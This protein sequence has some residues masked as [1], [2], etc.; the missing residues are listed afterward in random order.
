MWNK[1]R[2]LKRLYKRHTG[3]AS[4]T[5]GVSFLAGLFTLALPVAIGQYYSFLFGYQSFKAKLLVFVP[6]DLT[7]INKFLAFFATLVILRV[8]FSFGEKY[9]TGV[10]GQLFVFDVRNLLFEHQLKIPVRDYEDKG[11]GRYLLRF[12]GDLNSIRRYVTHGIIRFI[13]DTILILLSIGL[14]FRLDWRLG[15]FMILGLVIPLVV[16]LR[17]QNTLSTVTRRQRN[18]KSKLLAFA[19]TRLQ[20]VHTIQLFNKEI[21]EQAKFTRIAKSTLKAGIEY[22]KIVSLI[23]ALIPGLLYFLLAGLFAFVYYVFPDKTGSSG[24]DVLIFI[25]ILL[26]IMPV[27]RRMLR[28]NIIWELGNISFEK[29]LNVFNRVNP[30]DSQMP[31]LV[32]K[33]GEIMI[34][35]LSYRFSS[36]NKEL[37]RSLSMHIPRNQLTVIEGKSG[38]GKTTLIKL[39]SGLYQAQKGTIIIDDCDISK[40][41]GK[42][43][44]RK[45]A[46]I[47][48]Q[49]PLLGSTVFEAISYS[50][51]FEKRKSAQFILNY[52]QNNNPNLKRMKLDDPIGDLGAQLSKGQRKLLAYARALLT[53]KPILLVDEPLQGLDLQT[54]SFWLNELQSL[55]RNKTVVIFTNETVQGMGAGYKRISITRSVAGICRTA[56]RI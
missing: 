8:A 9:C 44:R 14:F 52:L 46:V 31:D 51:K 2:L 56:E 30:S 13:N 3:L 21:P 50:R 11:A 53:G 1:T 26:T 34:D 4:L 12:S 16:I 32:L 33:R 6:L 47:S 19:S 15:V 10:L 43:L 39:I 40:I 37:F 35:K 42:S 54:C 24:G 55:A 28:A 20:A 49:W 7:D 27:M 22:Q 29:L 36:T 45:I 48:D 17:L 23:N 25:I 38:I 18:R 5:F 41:N